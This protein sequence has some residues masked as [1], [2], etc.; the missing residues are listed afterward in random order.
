M[1]RI[2][3]TAVVEDVNKVAIESKPLHE[4]IVVVDD[5]KNSITVF[6]EEERERRL[7]FLSSATILSQ[8][9]D[10]SA[11]FQKSIYS[12]NNIW[13]LFKGIVLFSIAPKFMEPILYQITVQTLFTLDFFCYALT[14]SHSVYRIIIIINFHACL[15]SLH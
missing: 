14:E 8:C 11:V 2:N 10:K 5:T 7:S 6:K 3:I 4:K 9:Q 1:Y 13:Y 12:T 15:A